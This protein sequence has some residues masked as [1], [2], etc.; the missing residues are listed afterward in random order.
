MTT[1]I[2]LWNHRSLFFSLPKVELHPCTQ[3]KHH[4]I[5]RPVNN[6]H[7]CHMR[8]VWQLGSAAMLLVCYCTTSS[9]HHHFSVDETGNWSVCCIWPLFTS[10]GVFETGN[11]VNSCTGF[12]SNFTAWT[13]H[14]HMKHLPPPLHNS[15]FHVY[16]NRA[17]SSL[18]CT[19]DLGHLA[20]NFYSSLTTFTCQCDSFQDK[21][22]IKTTTTGFLA[23]RNLSQSL[24]IPLG[25]HQFRS[26]RTMTT[27]D[28]R[29]MQL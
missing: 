10:H 25:N 6:S 21:R 27:D 9:Q 22:Q 1:W 26:Q 18:A 4:K 13:V 8:S 28:A 14:S 12:V 11:H 19:A 17:V 7:A 24:Q 16:T 29:L 15:R 5:V 2:T 3:R 20:H 23:I